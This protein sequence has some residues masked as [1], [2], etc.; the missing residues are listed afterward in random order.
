MR[1][2]NPMGLIYSQRIA[3]IYECI[4]LICTTPQQY[5]IVTTS[6]HG[7]LRHD[8][9]LK[10]LSVHDHTRTATCRHALIAVLIM[11]TTGQYPVYVYAHTISSI[12][13]L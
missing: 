6:A 12:L 4:G 13:T 7:A 3:T 1:R 11:S 2:A 8:A 10:G 5:C 9:V